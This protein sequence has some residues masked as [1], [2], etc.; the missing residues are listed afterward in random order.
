LVAEL[1]FWGTAPLP[2][3][4]PSGAFRRRDPFWEYAGNRFYSVIEDGNVF[5]KKHKE[6]VFMKNW[7]QGLT[8]LLAVT[9]LGSVCPAALAAEVPT[10]ESNSDL[11]AVMQTNSVQ[12]N[13]PDAISPSTSAQ[14]TVGTRVMVRRNARSFTGEALD[15]ATY[16]R[17]YVIASFDNEGAAYIARD[18]IVRAR[19]NINDLYEI[20]VGGPIIPQVSM[21]T[22]VTIPQAATDTTQYIE[23]VI[24]PT[25]YIVGNGTVVSKGDQVMVRSG[26]WNFDN[27]QRLNVTN[28]TTIYNLSRVQGSHAY[29]AENGVEV[30]DIKLTDVVPTTY[31]IATPTNY[32]VTVDAI[33]TD[34]RARELRNVS[35]PTYTLSAEAQDGGHFVRLRDLAGAL[36]GTE[37]ARIQLGS[38]N[39][40]TNIVHGWSYSADGTE[41]TPCFP[42]AGIATRIATTFAVDGKTYQADGIY[43]VD[44]NGYGH[45]YYRLEDLTP[46]LGIQINCDDDNSRISIGTLANY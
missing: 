1:P 38:I 14:L 30:L 37:T 10:T 4:A 32:A 16:T 15:P 13:G 41:G 20:N 31:H 34:S 44:Y 35:M 22:D 40:V 7:K 9:M 11:V 17:E 25:S 45:S 33:W 3:P 2:F 23:G 36:S 12:N 24:P 5:V 46:I 19:M 21:G 18:G 8:S 39:G 42:G 28:Y 26:A 29:L 6:E 43:I 27:S